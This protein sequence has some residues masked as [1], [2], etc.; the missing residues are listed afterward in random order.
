MA[1]TSRYLVFG[2][3]LSVEL[4]DPD[5]RNAFRRWCGVSSGALERSGFEQFADLQLLSVE[6]ISS[7]GRRPVR[8]GRPTTASPPAQSCEFR[9]SDPPRLPD[10]WSPSLLGSPAS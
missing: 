4:V 7:R 3:A 10:R 5:L 2:A 6:Q 1:S 9:A 8:Q